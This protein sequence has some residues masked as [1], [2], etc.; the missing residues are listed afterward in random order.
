MSLLRSTRYI[1]RK[2]DWHVYLPN[3]VKVGDYAP[4]PRS[5]PI[6]ENSKDLIQVK[7]QHSGEKPLIF[8]EKLN[9]CL[10][11]I[12]GYLITEGHF[13]RGSSHEIGFT[14]KDE[15][16]LKEMSSLMLG[17]F[18]IEASQEPKKRWRNHIEVHIN[19]SVQMV[20]G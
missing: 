9:S 13:Y 4:A 8:P 16:L 12:L 18:G 14:N 6:N 10:S 15:D 19:S 5:I 20:R 2:M 7:R 1:S 3:N 17:S 11:R